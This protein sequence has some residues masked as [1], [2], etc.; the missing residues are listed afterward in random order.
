M[1]SIFTIFVE[2]FNAMLYQLKTGRTI[3]ISLEQYLS[4]DESDFE[5]VIASNA[6]EELE[7]PFAISVLKYGDIDL[8]EDEEEFQDLLDI[9]I[10]EKLTDVDF[11]NYDELT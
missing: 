2:I 4:M 5:Y 1:L 11:I 6:G 8:D 7:D 9:S 3:E 10:E